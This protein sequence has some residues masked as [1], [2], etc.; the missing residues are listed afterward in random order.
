MLNIEI[1][2]PARLEVIAGGDFPAVFADAPVE[3]RDTARH[4]VE[5]SFEMC[6]D[7]PLGIPDTYSTSG[8]S[9]TNSF[10]FIPASVLVGG[11]AQMILLDFRTNGIG[12]FQLH[13]GELLPSVETG[14]NT[15]RLVAANGVLEL[16]GPDAPGNSINDESNPYDWRMA[17]MDRDRL[18]AWLATYTGGEVTLRICIGAGLPHLPG[19]W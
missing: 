9:Y 11:Q 14:M 7:V 16:N 6:V 1:R 4:V 15:L 17:Q 12:A 5:A 2:A 3:S 10:P 13:I 8:I 19:P 18:G